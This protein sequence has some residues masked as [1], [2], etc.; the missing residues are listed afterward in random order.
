MVTTLPALHDRRHARRLAAATLAVFTISSGWQ[1]PVAADVWKERVVPALLAVNGTAIAT[2]WTLDLAGDRYDNRGS[3]FSIREGENLLWP[4]VVAELAT[5]GALLA[6]SYGLVRERQWGRTAALTSLGAL[7]YTSV[8]STS[9]TFA[10]RERLAY[11][12]P[13]AIALATGS[14]SLV[15]LW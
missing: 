11:T 9:W 12:I 10:K 6:S 1:R 2:M 15:V 4:H 5:A 14:A 3:F 8:N 7:L 13:M